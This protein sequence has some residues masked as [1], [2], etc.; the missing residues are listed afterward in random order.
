[1]NMNAFRKTHSP[2][3]RHRGF[4]LIEL[5]VVIAI[6]GILAAMIVPG[7]KHF[8]RKAQI[9]KVKTQMFAIST[10]IELYKDHFGH[11]PPGSGERSDYN[12]LYYELCGVELTK[13]NYVTLD[14]A[15]TLSR[16]AMEAKTLFPAVTGFA[17]T[18]QFRDE[19][20]QAKSF[21]AG[22]NRNVIVTAPNQKGV[23][24]LVG[25]TKKGVTATD[26]L[27][28]GTDNQPLNP[29]CY[30]V[31]SPNRI[32]KEKFD[33]WIDLVFSDG[34][35]NRIANWANDPIPNPTPRY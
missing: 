22:K 8:N 33:L 16:A 3:S 19:G 34:T 29:W 17:N 30:D 28:T 9:S 11:Y 31:S 2:G 14:G 12:Q 23:T 15:S 24:L 13:G 26:P 1:M 25:P 32:N 21:L 20:P 27:L 35:T 5:L 6:I 7:T 10:A 18:R 4:T